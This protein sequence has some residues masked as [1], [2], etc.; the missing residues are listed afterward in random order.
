MVFNA[1][2]MSVKDQAGYIE[3]KLSPEFLLEQFGYSVFEDN[4][5]TDSEIL[6][7]V[8]EHI[9]SYLSLCIVNLSIALDI[10]KFVIGGFILDKIESLVIKFTQEKITRLGLN[11]IHLQSTVTEYSASL[12]I[13]ALAIDK[14]IDD[15]LTSEIE[16]SDDMAVYGDSR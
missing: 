13:G 9:S 2:H 10:D 15:I 4:L 14:S 3:N 1:E 16:T 5:Q 11:P 12:G 8:A 7:R 6:V